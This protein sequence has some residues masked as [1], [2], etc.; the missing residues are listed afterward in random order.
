SVL[1]QATRLLPGLIVQD[2]L[3]AA[4]LTVLPTTG[5]A[6]PLRIPALDGATVLAGR[7]AYRTADLLLTVGGRFDRLRLVFSADF[8][9]ANI[10]RTEDVPPQEPQLISLGELVIGL[11]DDGALLLE[12]GASQR[13]V[14]DGAVG[15]DC[16]LFVD[17]GLMVSRDGVLYSARMRP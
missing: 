12:R 7:L 16:R 15:A 6:H 3:G 2:L 1:P 5:G 10:T 8:T 14:V 9:A 11:E 17:D 4:W 13:R